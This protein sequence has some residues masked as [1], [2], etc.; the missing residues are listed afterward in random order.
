MSRRTFQN[1]SMKIQDA[2]MQ[3]NLVNRIQSMDAP[4]EFTQL[5]NDFQ[6]SLGYDDDQMTAYLG[7]GRTVYREARCGTQDLPTH[8]TAIIMDQLDLIDVANG[9]SVSDV[10]SAILT[11]R[12]REKYLATKERNSFLKVDMKVMETLSDKYKRRFSQLP[13]TIGSHHAEE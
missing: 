12:S 3:N 13:Q 7:V 5:I 2:T 8:A 1:K 6:E 10:I 11:R 4:F 9:F